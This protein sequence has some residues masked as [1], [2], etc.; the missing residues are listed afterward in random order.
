MAP[1]PGRRTGQVSYSN[2]LCLWSP[3]GEHVY[4]LADLTL[5]QGGRAIVD[6]CRHCGD[7]TFQPMQNARPNGRNVWWRRSHRV[8]R[9]A[10]RG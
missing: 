9:R 2:S 7:L 8:N 3:T 10:D 4:Q 5:G 6:E 1:F